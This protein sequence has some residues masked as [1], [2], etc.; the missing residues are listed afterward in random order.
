MVIIFGGFVVASV[1]LFKP[2]TTAPIPA[3]TT[4]ELSSFSWLPNKCKALFSD[5]TFNIAAFSQA[6]GEL[7][8]QGAREELIQDSMGSPE[9]F[10]AVVE[11]VSR[12]N[13]YRGFGFGEL[14]KDLPKKDRQ[15]LFKVLY[16]ATKEGEVTEFDL[17]NVIAEVYR[18]THRPKDF[19]QVAWDVAKSRVNFD[20]LDNKKI[21]ERV[22][23][24][25]FNDSLKNS[26]SVVIKEPGAW[27]KVKSFLASRTF[28]VL[29]AS[30]LWTAT[31][32]SEYSLSGLS[33]TT[34]LPSFLFYLPPY[35]PKF[36]EFKQS[37]EIARLK[38]EVLN[39]GVD[40]VIRSLEAQMKL[41]V[42]TERKEFFHGAYT[43]IISAIFILSI[44][45]TAVESRIQVGDA[46]QH[47]DYIEKWHEEEMQK[48]ERTSRQEAEDDFKEYFG[49]A[50]RM[51]KSGKKVDNGT[52]YYLTH[53]EEW[54]Q[55][56][57]AAIEEARKKKAQTK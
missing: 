34:S 7:E 26:L 41:P 31:V 11:Y 1:W 37:P 29:L 38:G 10:L 9:K 21:I 14:I 33:T 56:D 35:I 48:A 47:T 2:V 28:D 54:I 46:Q 3:A 36:W 20:K 42:R 5:K 4:T 24:S 57:A 13:A 8:L 12:K 43:R 52:E 27:T 25:L 23:L 30:T 50:E 17:K 16:K 6:M 49:E 44:V 15:R 51:Y 40:Q 55:K 39:K 45:S 19:W 18:L 22:E 53:K 32:V